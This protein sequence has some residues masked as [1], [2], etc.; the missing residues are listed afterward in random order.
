MAAVPRGGRGTALRPRRR[1]PAHDAAAGDAGDRAAREDA[2]RDAFRSHTAPRGA[3]ASRRGLAAR[4]SG[5][6]GARA[7][8]AAARPCRRGGGGGARAAGLR[9]DHRVRAAA[10]VGEGIPG[11]VPAGRAGT[12]RGD[13]RR[14]T[15]RFL[16][17]GDRCRADAAFTRLRTARAGAADGLGGAAGAGLARRHM[18]WPRSRSCRWRRRWPSPS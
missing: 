7:I 2:R 18:R 12:G 9:V 15:R 8:L 6:A 4:R 1:A 3:H 10:P 16:P 14:A 13:R 17:R 5:S 11:A